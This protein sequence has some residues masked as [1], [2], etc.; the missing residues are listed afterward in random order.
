M[1]SETERGHWHATIVLGYKS[2]MAV[3]TLVST[4]ALSSAAWADVI[5]AGAETV[6][7][8]FDLSNQPPLFGQLSLGFPQV[9]GCSIP[10]G[11][12]ISG[13]TFGNWIAF[14][15]PQFNADDTGDIFQATSGVVQIQLN[16][17]GGVGLGPRIPSNFNSIGL[18]SQT[19][20]ATGGDVAF[21]FT[22]SNNSV[23]T[24][25]VSLAAGITGLQHFSFDE[26]NVNSVAFFGV[27]GKLLQ[28]DELSV[29]FF[30]SRSLAPSSVRACP[31]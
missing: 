20:D 3:A 9:C 22:H 5:S 25:I 4:I 8:D 26:Q 30:L 14:G 31:V 29:T 15:A 27:D 1:K 10:A 2:A 18:A 19:N 24:S 12:F 21:L 23:D 7:I 6:L 16:S 28:F 11:V 17:P 13:P